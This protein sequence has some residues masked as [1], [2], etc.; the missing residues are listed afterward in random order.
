MDKI[1]A[2]PMVRDLDHLPRLRAFGK[3]Y[4]NKSPKCNCIISI[5]YTKCKGRILQIFGWSDFYFVL[6]KMDFTVF[7]RREELLK[8]LAHLKLKENNGKLPCCFYV[9]GK[10][11]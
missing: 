8:R 11:L 3:F 9:P 7:P 4:F 2:V 10:M 6:V 5:V 1:F